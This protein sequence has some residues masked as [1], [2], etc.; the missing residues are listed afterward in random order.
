MPGYY[1]TQDKKCIGCGEFLVSWSEN[2]PAWWCQKRHCQR[3]G[4]STIM[5]VAPGQ[6]DT[7]EKEKKEPKE[8]ALV[9]PTFAP[10]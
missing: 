3:E 9:R 8:G 6:G 7:G 5:Y 4:L 2:G 10:L 1:V